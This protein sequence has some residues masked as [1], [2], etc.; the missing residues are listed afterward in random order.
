MFRL[1]SAATIASLRA[2]DA[3]IQRE[4]RQGLLGAAEYTAARARATDRFKDRTGETRR[5]IGVQGARSTSEGI[6]IYVVA[7]APQSGFLEDGTHAH[8]I[9][10]KSAGALR[11]V[12]AG[13]VRFARRVHHPGTKPTYF[14]RD[15]R[16]EGEQQLVRFVEAGVNRAIA[17]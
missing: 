4:A 16:D 7:G 9:E 2:L 13:T 5:R 1:D 17:G 12:V 14:M 11:F 8:T 10:P 15:A 6:S 3:A